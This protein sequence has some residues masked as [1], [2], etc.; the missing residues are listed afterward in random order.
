LAISLADFLAGIIS[1][2]TITVCINAGV[3][4]KKGEKTIAGQLWH[5]EGRFMTAVNGTLEG[6]PNTRESA[7]L[8]AAVEAAA[9]KDPI[10]QISEKG[11]RLT[12][13]TIIYPA[14]LPQLPEALDEFMSNPVVYEDGSHIAFSEIIEKCAEYEAIPR[15]LRE[16]SDMIQSDPELASVVPQWM[17]MAAQTAVGSH[18][19]VLENGPDVMNSEDEDS[20]KEEHGGV[21]TGI[22]VGDLKA[23]VLPSQ[24]EVARQKEAAAYAKSIGDGTRIDSG[25]NHPSE[26]SGF[27]DF[28]QSAPTS[29][30]HTRCGSRFDTPETFDSEQPRRSSNPFVSRPFTPTGSVPSHDTLATAVSDTLPVL[31]KGKRGGKRGGKKA[32]IRPAEHPMTTRTRDASRA[33]GLRGVSGS[34]ETDTRVANGNPSKT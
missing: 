11:K 31:K 22:Y 33:G 13:K 8:S 18:D 1:T 27:S 26:D 28:S 14:K 23:P 2:G 34:G 15:F 17:N 32:P 9:W 30:A 16:D 4:M 21:L 20:P 12:P 25:S 6:M 7:I 3:S 29:P 24:S 10:E 19:L 5:Q